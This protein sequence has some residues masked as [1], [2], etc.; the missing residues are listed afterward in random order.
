MTRQQYRYLC[1]NSFWQFIRIIGDYSIFKVKEKGL[2]PASPIIHK[3]LCEFWQ[4]N[5]IP[6]KA[7][8]MGRYWRKSTYYTCLNAMWEYLR[9]PDIR[10]LFA[11]QKEGLVGR[12][13]LFMERQFLDNEMLRWIYSDI[14]EK[15]DRRYKQGHPFS[16]ETCLMPR[17]GSYIENTYHVIGITGGSQGG[18]F[19]I[20]YG[21]DLISEKGMESALVMEDACRWFDNIHELLVETDPT[22]PN[23]SQIRIIGT[24]WK[25]GDLGEYIQYEYPEIQWRIVPALRTLTWVTWRVTGPRHTPQKNT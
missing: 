7:L 18:H 10:I 21:D 13:L 24:H 17:V 11:S 22:H 6:Y 8:Y 5:S 2:Q 14:L 3:P 12:F 19:D 16:S 20:V 4:D 9:N 23:A 15:V 1:D 25:P